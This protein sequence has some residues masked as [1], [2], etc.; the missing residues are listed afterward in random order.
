MPASGVNILDLGAVHLVLRMF[1]L[2]S[3][4]Q[5]ANTLFIGCWT[6]S[7][8]AGGSGAPSVGL[9][10]SCKFHGNALVWCTVQPADMLSTDSLL[11]T[12]AVRSL[13]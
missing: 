12:I 2:C 4:T 8:S 10:S 3:E 6:Q 5:H 7:I 1:M 9:A 13:A 11:D